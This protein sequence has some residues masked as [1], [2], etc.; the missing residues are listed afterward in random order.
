[1]G[2]VPGWQPQKKKNIYSIKR[3]PQ[4]KPNKMK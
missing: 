4:K 2:T 1:M 3:K